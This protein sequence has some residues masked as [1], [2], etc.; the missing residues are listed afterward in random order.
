MCAGSSAAI[1][2]LDESQWCRDNT[3]TMENKPCELCPLVDAHVHLDEYPDT[4]LGPVLRQLE[5][6]R[7]VSISTAMAPQAYERSL[8]IQERSEF[9]LATLGVH[10][11]NAPYF[12]TRLDEMKEQMGSSPMFGE[13]GLDFRKVQDGMQHEAQRRVFEFFLS[14]A[15]EQGKIVNVHT[16][17]AEA[18]A[19][20]LL[21]RHGIERGIMHWYAGPSEPLQ[22][23]VARGYYFTF[24][25]E[26][27]V[28]EQIQSLAREVPIGQ[29]LTETDNP[30]GPQL[31]FGDAA[32]PDIVKTVLEALAIVH[33]MDIAEMAEHIR[34][35]ML[36]L[37][38][39]DNRLERLSTALR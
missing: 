9:V 34:A 26:L 10:P 22:R 29:L 24:G 15:K 37:I 5:E 33:G 7:I 35:N 30:G 19:L 14:A 16:W 39:D 17:G 12:V 6:D 8:L 2:L 23:M 3:F 27:L 32:M 1:G 31:V 25:S 36:R 11:W 20:E 4:W 21:E 28:S 13:I 38:G 18:E